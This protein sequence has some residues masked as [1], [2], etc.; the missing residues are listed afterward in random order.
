MKNKSQTAFLLNSR[1]ASLVEYILLMVISV[2][3]MYTLTRIF[4]QPFGNYLDSYLG[5]YTQCLL[6]TGELPVLGGDS[7]VEDLESCVARLT[8]GQADALQ[9]PAGSGGGAGASDRNQSSRD[10]EGGE[11]S[12]GAGSATA[13]RRG[14]RIGS[15]SS[16]TDG[17]GGGAASND[18]RIVIDLNEDPNNR[19]FRSNS[20]SNTARQTQGRRGSMIT[21]LPNEFERQAIERRQSSRRT[22]AVDVGS[23]AK[24][25]KKMAVKPPP[26][27]SKQTE[28]QD[29]GFDFAY[30]MK[31]LFILGVLVLILILMGGFFMQLRQT[32]RK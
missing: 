30:V 2:S 12:G 1:G 26:A 29:D 13:P 25:N 6:E 20:S 21:Y 17:G 10:D 3:L 28:A 16:G 32:M 9:T 4:W 5:G 22:I 15:S 23:F 24:P 27:V 7:T 18:K 19:F 8:T 31:L 14:G 11:G